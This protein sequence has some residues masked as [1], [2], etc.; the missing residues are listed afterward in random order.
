MGSSRSSRH[1]ASPIPCRDRGVNKTRER[2]ALRT[3]QVELGDEVIHRRPVLP[4]IVDKN[5]GTLV[6]GDHLAESWPRVVR[7]WVLRRHIGP[8][9]DVR[10][11]EYRR[12]LVYERQ[13][14]WVRDEE[15]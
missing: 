10:C 8:L 7:H 1:M 13:L 3:Y 14:F 4:D 9:D 15:R 6:V 2:R 12:P 11:L 5:N